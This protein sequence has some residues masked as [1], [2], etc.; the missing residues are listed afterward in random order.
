MKP[1]ELIEKVNEASG[2]EYRLAYW[3]AMTLIE[4]LKSL[5]EIQFFVTEIKSEIWHMRRNQ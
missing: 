2:N 1:D 4:M 3:M 5:L